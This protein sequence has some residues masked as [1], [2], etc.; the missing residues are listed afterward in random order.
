MSFRELVHDPTFIF[1]GTNYDVWKIRMLNLFR[2]MG[3]N[4][5]KRIVDVNLSPPKDSQ[6]LSLEDEENSHLETRVSNG[7][8][9]V[10]SDVV[11]ASIMPFGTLMNFG[12]SF[13]IYMKCPKLLRMIVLLP[14]L[15]VMSSQIPLHQ[16]V[17]C[18]KVMI[19]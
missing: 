16:H 6:E 18:H 10:L 19:W 1:D 4:Y 7:L 13:K 17:I 12:P 8:I 14:L 3:P 9:C 5:I 11:L 2:A 15:A